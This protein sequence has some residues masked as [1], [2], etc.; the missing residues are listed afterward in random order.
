MWNVE[1]GEMIH[2]P[3]ILR[4]HDTGMV[5][6]TVFTAHSRYFCSIPI[7]TDGKDVETGSGDNGVRC[8]GPGIEEVILSNNTEIGVHVSRIRQGRKV[9][10]CTI[11]TII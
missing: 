11:F 10:D 9:K 4:E 6:E 8:V 7:T 3:W 2:G 1:R 5:S